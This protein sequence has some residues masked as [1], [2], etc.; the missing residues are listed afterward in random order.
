MR[1]GVC[2]W[3]PEREGLRWGSRHRSV[4]ARFARASGSDWVN[5]DLQPPGWAWQSA[6][7]TPPAIK[8]C[9]FSYRFESVFP[10]V[11]CPSPCHSF[12]SLSLSLLNEVFFTIQM[13]ELSVQ[14]AGMLTAQLQERNGYSIL[15][16]GSGVKTWLPSVAG[17]AS[18]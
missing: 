8:R 13:Q 4:P 7:G 18:T 5:R 9:T 10:T 17:R 6:A 16:W 14:P 11:F 12:C 3:K 2:S 15:F 1:E